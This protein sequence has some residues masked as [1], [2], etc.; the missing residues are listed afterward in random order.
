MFIN[1]I[2]SFG[3]GILVM[4]MG[5]FSQAETN[6]DYQKAMFRQTLKSMKTTE[7]AFLAMALVEKT[8]DSMMI[9]ARDLRENKVPGEMP[10]LDVKDNKILIDGKDSEVSIKTYSPLTLEYRNKT[11][12][13]NT[14][15][16]LDENYT[17]LKKFFTGPRKSASLMSLFI[18]EARADRLRPTEPPN[19]NGKEVLL[20][21]AKF[22]IALGVGAGAAMD[23]AFVAE[24]SSA[25]TKKE[26]A[27]DAIQSALVYGAGPAAPLYLQAKLNSREFGGE[28]SVVCE[29][30]KLKIKNYLIYLK[31]DPKSLSGINFKL[32]DKNTET[33]FGHSAT[34]LEIVKNSKGE[35]EYYVLDLNGVRRATYT[36]AEYDNKLIADKAAKHCFDGNMPKNIDQEIKKAIANAHAA[37]FAHLGRPS[38]NST[39]GSGT[40]KG[41]N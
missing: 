24:F 17:D 27:K 3:L 26:L 16:P 37:S 10:Q 29:D 34:T 1:R 41:T 28:R 8:T 7:D 18:S 23:A 19:P 38:K 6:L 35:N 32:L 4:L 2:A 12:S 13:Y 9:I 20:D 14:K 11:W 40:Q 33:F 5:V 30:G 39:S 15:H 36:Y 25:M 31:G 21:V 22:Y